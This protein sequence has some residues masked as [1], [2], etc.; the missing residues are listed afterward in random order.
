MENASPALNAGI[1]T[2]DM[3]VSLG[4]KNVEGIRSFSDM[5]LEC[6]TREIVQVKI[7]RKTEDGLR[8]MTLEVALTGKK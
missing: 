7:L 5:I 8:E 3:I 1:K 6:S 2:G 4:G